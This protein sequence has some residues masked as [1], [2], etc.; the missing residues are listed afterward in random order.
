VHRVAA[1]PD[2]DERAGEARRHAA[3]AP[4]ADMLAEQRH[5]QCGD[6][7]RRRLHDCRGVGKRQEIQRREKLQCRCH[8]Q[9]GPHDLQAAASGRQRRR[10]PPPQHGG[11]QKGVKEKSRP[12]DLWH[13]IARDQVFHHGVQADEQQHRHQHPG[14]APAR[15][16]CR[17]GQC[18]RGHPGSSMMA[19]AT[20]RRV[21]TQTTAPTISAPP[22]NCSMRGVVPNHMATSTPT[23]GVRLMNMAAT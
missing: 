5:G 3:P 23:I 13:G 22:S 15:I 6:D 1:R 11:Q 20:L 18:R 7:Q 16:R 17:R 10:Q 8:Q 14:D 19:T 12:D 4:N 9:S 21:C 2:D